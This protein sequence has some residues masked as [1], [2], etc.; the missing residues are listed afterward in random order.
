MFSS[1]FFS[2]NRGIYEMPWKNF[3]E[4]C[5][6]QMTIQRMRI[7]CWSLRLQIHKLGLCNSFYFYTT[8][9][10]PITPRKVM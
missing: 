2:E 9:M 7:A 3:V 10:V 4:R 8:T 5:R 6:S 1:F